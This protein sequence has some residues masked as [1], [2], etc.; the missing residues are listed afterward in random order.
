MEAELSVLLLVELS[1]GQVTPLSM[2]RTWSGAEVGAPL[3]E[4]M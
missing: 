4:E 2:E 3:G 1:V